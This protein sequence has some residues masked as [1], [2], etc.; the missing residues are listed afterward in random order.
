[1]ARVARPVDPGKIR[2]LKRQ[3][4]DPV[5][6][7]IAVQTLAGRMTDRL[8]GVDEAMPYVPDQRSASS[9]SKEIAALLRDA[10]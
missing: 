5:Y 10:E 4:H 9:S 3:I 6:I 8:L 2:Q 7:S 1:M